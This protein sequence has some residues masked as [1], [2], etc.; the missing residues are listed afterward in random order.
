MFENKRLSLLILLFISL[1]GMALV[2]VVAHIS[3]S[4]AEASYIQYT[5]ATPILMTTPQ[6]STV[7]N[8]TQAPLM[9]P[10]PAV[11]YLE[12]DRHYNYHIPTVAEV[13]SKKTGVDG[14]KEIQGQG[15]EGGP[16][17]GRA[18]FGYGTDA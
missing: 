4:S 5:T 16:A 8:S 15:R 18:G 3:Q 11:K 10:A 14:R 17:A 7:P 13:A 6:I 12:V 9:P 1:L 2:I